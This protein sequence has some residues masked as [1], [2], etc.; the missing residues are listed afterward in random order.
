[1][2]SASPAG[3][4]EAQLA[5]RELRTLALSAETHLPVHE[6]MRVVVRK[7][8]IARR[9]VGE[10]LQRLVRDGVLEYLYQYGATGVAPCFN[11]PVPVSSRLALVPAG[12]SFGSATQQRPVFLALGSA[13]GDGR[14]PT[15]RLALEGL[16]H[17]CTSTGA[18]RLAEM[19]A[20]DIGTGTGV[21][22]IA[23]GRLGVGRVVALDNA[24][25]AV[26]EARNNV[27]CNRLE[28]VVAVSDQTL[29]AVCGPFNLVAAN[30][31]P[32][33][34]LVLV[35][36]ICSKLSPGGTAVLTGFRALE[37]EDVLAPYTTA[38]LDLASIAERAGW[39]A[40]VLIRRA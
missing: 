16:E 13:F 37:T 30:L 12:Q 5:E 40:A 38:G 32:P 21:L 34:L 36:E 3:V 31:R 33:T 9:I 17:W 2:R 22:A 4:P 28:T 20:L 39:T 29:D 14:H 27:A 25:G 18:L 7:T 26:E 10:A 11:R 15:T 6:L 1:M 35:Q 8:G 24:P 23:L 19:R